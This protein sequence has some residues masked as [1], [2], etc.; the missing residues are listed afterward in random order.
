MWT[1]DIIKKGIEADDTWDLKVK[2]MQKY[3]KALRKEV[4]EYQKTI[5]DV[6]DITFIKEDW[7]VSRE[8]L[9][10]FI[11]RAYNIKITTFNESEESDSIKHF[12]DLG[13]VRENEI[14]VFLEAVLSDDKFCEVVISGIASLHLPKVGYKW[15]KDT[16]D[17]SVINY[18]YV[19]EEAAD[20]LKFHFIEGFFGHRSLIPSLVQSLNF[21]K[22]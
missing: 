11:Y 17:F 12:F 7:E 21:D 20:V 22:A 13:Q 4:E 5:E 10:S 6:L 8:I 14:H 15:K 2:Q 19:I 3:G 9:K 16:K 1:Q 18:A